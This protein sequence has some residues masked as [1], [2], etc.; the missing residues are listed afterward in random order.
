MFLVMLIVLP[1]E[2]NPLNLDCLTRARCRVTSAELRIFIRTDKKKHGQVTGVANRLCE[3]F[4]CTG[5]ETFG[6][7]GSEG[8]S[9]TITASSSC[10]SSSKYVLIFVNRTDKCLPLQ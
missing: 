9:P 1:R 4:A 8:I 5:V 10:T 7:R 3:Y 2:L 6:G